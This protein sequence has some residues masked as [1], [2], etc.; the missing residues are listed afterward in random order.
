MVVLE[1]NIESSLIVHSEFRSLG[2]FP[3]LPAGLSFK[4]G[5]RLGTSLR[6]EPRAKQKPRSPTAFSYV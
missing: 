6:P 1:A 2:C 5:E 4:V 3:R